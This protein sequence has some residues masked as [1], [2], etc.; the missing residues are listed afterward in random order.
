MAAGAFDSWAMVLFFLTLNSGNDLVSVLDPAEYFKARK[1]QVTVDKMVE[2][3]TTQASNGKGQVQ[4]LFAL[5]LLAQDAAE[6]K[7]AKNFADILKSI[8]EVAE[9]KK[10]QDLQGFAAEYARKTAIAL[11]SQLAPTKEGIPE[12][13][14]KQDAVSW[15]PKQSTVVL[16][17]DYRNDGAQGGKEMDELRKK[18]LA[19]MPPFVTEQIYQAAEEMGN[20][21]LDRFSLGCAE[22][23]QNVNDGDVYLRFTGKLDHKRF[24]AYLKKKLPGNVQFKETK[25]F[26]GKPISLFWTPNQAPAIALVGDNDLI[27]AGPM[28]GPNRDSLKIVEEVLDVHRG[29]VPSVLEGPLAAK[30]KTVSPTAV[31]MIVGNVPQSMHKEMTRDMPAGPGYKAFPKEVVIEMNYKG[32]DLQVKL[33]TE[34]KDAEEAK[35]FVAT[36]NALVQLGLVQLQNPPPFPPNFPNTDKLLKGATDLLKSIKVDAKGKDISG[37]LTV[38]PELI[39]S[40]MGMALF[41][42]AELRGAAAPL[43]P[44]PAPPAVEKKFK[45]IDDVR[46]SLPE[47]LSPARNHEPI[48]PLTMLLENVA[49][50]HGNTREV[51]AELSA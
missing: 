41:L 26:R 13:S 46:L 35:S 22:N 25:S 6:V 24:V 31:G 3:A 27:M 15:F 42:V 50:G 32:K 8:E 47:T 20:V 19:S 44:P 40:Y 29:K 51:P 1:V 4:Q 43:P 21:R 45:A 7:K 16:S 36:T 38:G 37:S 28:G 33:Q 49:C 10:A 5:R 39:Q 23:A 2:L 14:A 17:L 18:L 48:T 9:G 12:N 34:L 11:G 30:L